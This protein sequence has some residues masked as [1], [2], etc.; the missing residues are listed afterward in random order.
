MRIRR[1]LAATAVGAVLA[2]G[3]AAAPAVA[4]T[5][6]TSSTPLYWVNTGETFNRYDPCNQ[7]G[8]W[9]WD[10]ESDV[11]SWDCRW[12]GSTYKLWLQKG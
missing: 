6:S 7:R 9:Y 4:A 5:P 11:Y 3:A 12:S 1:A 10:N 8:A 2:V